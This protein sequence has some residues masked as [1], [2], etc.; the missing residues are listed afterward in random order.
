MA[1]FCWRHEI[2]RLGW[3]PLDQIKASTR[4]EYLTDE[5][6]LR[7]LQT[8][9]NFEFGQEQCANLV[10][11]LYNVPLAFVQAAAFIMVES[12][13][14][15]KYLHM[16][17]HSD[18]SKIQLLGDEFEDELRDKDTQ[19][20]VALTLIISFEQIKKSDPHA[21]EIL[22]FISMLENREICRSLYPHAVAILFSLKILNDSVSS[23]AMPLSHKTQLEME[24]DL[25]HNIA[26]TYI[27]RVNSKRRS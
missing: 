2:R 13:L 7:L 6:L 20:A 25:L 12:S 27:T 22:S 3:N 23:Y 21:A 15:L 17:N 14:I 1:P 10:T 26:T 5:E 18:E 11:A 9:L 8:K 24:S 4:F 19:N 16:Y